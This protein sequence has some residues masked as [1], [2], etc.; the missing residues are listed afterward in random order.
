MTVNLQTTDT[1]LTTTRN[2]RRDGMTNDG[3]PTDD[4]DPGTRMKE[5]EYRPA[6]YAQTA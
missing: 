2:A 6:V 5:V 4:P 1:E 3:A